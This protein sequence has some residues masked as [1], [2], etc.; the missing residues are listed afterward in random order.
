MKRKKKAK[1]N[2]KDTAGNSGMVQ[3]R[4]KMDELQENSNGM[5]GRRRKQTTAFPCDVKIQD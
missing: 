3:M 5:E 1:E 4:G 2:F